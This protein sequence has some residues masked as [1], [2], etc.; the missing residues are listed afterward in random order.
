MRSNDSPNT[1]PV[2]LPHWVKENP[3]MLEAIQLIRATLAPEKIF[4]LGKI[5]NNT[6][7]T[8]VEYDFLVLVDNT[9]GRSLSRLEYDFHK[10]AIEKLVHAG[11]T[12]MTIEKAN[13]IITQNN[14]FFSIF[15]NP[16]YLVYDAM[17]IKLAKIPTVLQYM[18][19]DEVYKEHTVLKKKAATFL[20]AAH[21]FYEFEEYDFC[22]LMLH[23]ATE[24]FLKATL[25]PLF[26]DFTKTHNL[27]KLFRCVRR[28]NSTIYNVFC[29]RNSAEID[30]F[31][32]LQHSYLHSRFRDN[33]SV[34]AEQATQLLER[35]QLLEESIEASFGEIISVCIRDLKR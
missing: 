21:T 2:Y 13:E 31:L 1:L 14:P 33:Y 4:L 23:Q 27:K 9:M 19:L 17:R 5:P 28:V 30:L 6:I 22:S 18:E 32:V 34:T 3:T 35:V 25:Q 12:V 16:A 20:C 15:C 24:Y 26:K 8:G 29:R 11:I 7:S 10:A